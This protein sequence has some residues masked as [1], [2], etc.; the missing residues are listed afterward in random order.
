MNFPQVIPWIPDDEY[1]KATP[2][3]KRLRNLRK[4]MPAAVLRK[5]ARKPFKKDLLCDE[6]RIDDDDSTPSL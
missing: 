6:W 3:T 4:R 5:A 2:V 1:Y